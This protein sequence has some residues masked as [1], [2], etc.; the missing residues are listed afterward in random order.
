MTTVKNQIPVDTTHSP[1]QVAHCIDLQ[2]LS[3]RYTNITK[4]IQAS[5]NELPGRKRLF[6][7]P[8]ETSFLEMVLERRR[9]R[10][11]IP[12]ILEEPDRE[13]QEPK[14]KRTRDTDP[15]DPQTARTSNWYRF[16]VEKSDNC[17]D[18]K[19]K[20]ARNFDEDS[21]CR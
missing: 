20:K 17:M 7:A 1:I 3:S 4:R 9:N 2:M 16:Y 6:G 8:T 5:E 12:P 21:G 14:A 19:K 13:I 15:Y 10:D 11:A 18:P